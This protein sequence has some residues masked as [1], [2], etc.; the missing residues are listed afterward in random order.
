MDTSLMEN[1]SKITFRKNLSLVL[2]GTFAYLDRVLCLR[3]LYGIPRRYNLTL[4]Y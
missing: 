4:I 3:F 1:P 2:M